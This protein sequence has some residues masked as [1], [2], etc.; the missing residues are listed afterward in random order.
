MAESSEESSDGSNVESSEDFDSPHRKAA[1]SVAW[2]KMLANFHPGKSSQERSIV[3][4]FL[5]GQQFDNEVVHAVVSLV[6]EMVYSCVHGH[7]QGRKMAN[8]TSDT[9]ASK[10]YPESEETVQ[11][12]WSGTTPYD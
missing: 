6:Q 1:F 10:M 9:R 7:V 2:M 8:T 3:E 5:V 4:R 11:I 12:L